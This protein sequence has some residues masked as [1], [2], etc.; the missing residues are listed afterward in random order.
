[1]RSWA[2]ERV[3]A[4]APARVRGAY[5]RALVLFEADAIGNLLDIAYLCRD[6]V[7]AETWTDALDYQFFDFGD[8]GA[9]CRDCEEQIA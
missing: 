3:E 9:Y 2:D 1:L 4:N 7:D 6:C 8:G 5:G